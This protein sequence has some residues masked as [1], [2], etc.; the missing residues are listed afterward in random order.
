[1]NWLDRS[2]WHLPAD[3]FMNVW[4]AVFSMSRTFD[5]SL[6]L[7]GHEFESRPD[8]QVECTRVA[9]MHGEEKSSQNCFDN[10]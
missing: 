7:K 10:K 6:P 3:I 1:L 9:K 5:K 4:R 8:L 2:L